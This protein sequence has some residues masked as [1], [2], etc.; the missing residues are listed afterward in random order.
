MTV[1]S[2]QERL[3]N[4][5]LKEYKHCSFVIKFK[6]AQSHHLEKS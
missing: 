1:P 6:V 5:A 4:E 2:S 3:E